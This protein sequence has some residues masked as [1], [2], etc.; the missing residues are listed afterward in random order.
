[1]LAWAMVGV[2]LTVLVSAVDARAPGRPF[3]DMLAFVVPA[4]CVWWV[5]GPLAFYL[6]SRFPLVG[7]SWHRWLPLHLVASVLTALVIGVGASAWYLVAFPYP[8]QISADTTFADVYELYLVT[9]EFPTNLFIYWMLVVGSSALGYYRKFRERELRAARLEAELGRASLRALK[10]QL[11]PHFLF[12]TLNTVSALVLK[13]ESS[14]AIG[15]LNHLA[16]FLRMTLEDEGAQEVPLRRELAFA[17][18]YLAIEQGRFPDRLELRIE[19][20]PEALDV[21]VPNLLLQPLVENCVRYAR[22]EEGVA[23]LSIRAARRHG[24]LGLELA[25]NGPGLCHPNSRKGLGIGLRNVEARL[26]QLY[27]DDF[28]FVLKSRPGAGLRVSFELPWRRSEEPVAEAR[29]LDMPVADPQSLEPV[30]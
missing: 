8:E 23:Q 19:V 17:E 24:R 5:F 2:L 6:G 22:P 29:L 18:K 1:M 12:N 9:G 13:K 7:R 14:N 27:D 4:W 20:E 10:M 30:V 11:Q 26:Q 25:D 28:A 21:L 15:M 16:D 3:L